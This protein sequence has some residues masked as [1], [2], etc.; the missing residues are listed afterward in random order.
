MDRSNMADDHAH[1]RMLLDDADEPWASPEIQQNYESALGRFMLAFNRLDNLLEETLT[2][3]PSR[4]SRNDLIKD[5]E[6]ADF[7]RKVRFLDLLK[8]SGE[9][10]GIE[11][12]S[13]TVFK[14]I[15]G[16]RNFLAHG[17]FDQNPFDGSYV[18]TNRRK[19]SYFSIESIDA[20]TD[21]ATNA[22]DALS[23]AQAVYRY[24]FLREPDAT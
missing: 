14:E 3:I 8:H 22:C 11:H 16:A 17:H 7:S 4:L 10:Y 18:V 24:S 6:S 1:E 20:L 21:Q 19:H 9:G 12:V 5:Y 15:A 13:I 2:I 23:G